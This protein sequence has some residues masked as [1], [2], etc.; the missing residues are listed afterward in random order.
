MGRY[1][2]FVNGIIK[3]TLGAFLLPGLLGVDTA[4]AVTKEKN[5][6]TY[7]C[8]SVLSISEADYTLKKG[9]EPPTGTE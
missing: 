2:E 9:A 7:G 8:G 3:I 4:V 6:H 1:L 5:Y